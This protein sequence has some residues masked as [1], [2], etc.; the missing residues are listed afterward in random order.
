[1]SA[2]RRQNEEAT[3]PESIRSRQG[4]R[5]ERDEKARAARKAEEDRASKSAAGL[6]ELAAGEDDG[7]ES[8]AAYFATVA[9]SPEEMQLLS[10][11]G[12]GFFG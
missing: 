6:A 10:M 11:V 4:S 7:S 3:S 12:T 5:D 9:P 8:V 2:E 1:M